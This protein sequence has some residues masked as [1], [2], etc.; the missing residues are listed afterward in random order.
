MIKDKINR[1]EKIIGTHLTTG[2]FWV[3]DI[4]GMSGIDYVW[5]D[6]EHSHMDYRELLE[7]ITI[8]KAH[9]VAAFVRTQIDDFNHTKR[10]LD[11]GVDGIIFPMVEDKAQAEKC[12][13]YTYYPPKGIRGFGPARAVEYGRINANQYI[14]NEDTLCRFIQIESPNAINNLEEIATVS[15]IDGFI[16]GP[17]DLSVNCAHHINCFDSTPQS[18]IHRIIEILK[19]HNRYVGVSIGDTDADIQKRWF[20][21]G[22]DMLS[23]GVDTKFVYDGITKTVKQLTD[24]INR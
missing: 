12:I 5:I 3:A 17:C 19:K 1:G 16:I 14:S 11:M 4:Y 2:D 13:S 18:Q 9:G 8:L 20:D 15:G 22:I 23:A 21:T 6:T 7:C 10:I 24:I